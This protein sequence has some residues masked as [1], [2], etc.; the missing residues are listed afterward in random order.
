MRLV[1]LLPAM[2]LFASSQSSAQTR[3]QTTAPPAAAPS[4]L[5]GTWE[6]L[7]RSQ[8]G[9]GSIMIFAPGD[10]VK[11]IVSV[12]VD[13]RYTRDGNRVQLTHDDGNR[14]ELTVAITGDTLVQ[15]T[16]GKSVSMIR[17]S[18]SGPD[19]GIVGRWRFPY[20]AP[21]MPVVLGTMEYTADGVNR[22]RLPLQT[23]AGTYSISGSELTVRLPDAPPQTGTFSIDGDVLTLQRPDG[24]RVR[25]ARTR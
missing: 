9:I 21:Q 18:G 17:V 4:P 1:P 16:A 22:L 20:E 25:F 19:S 3:S 7:D 10:S 2:L 23:R 12:M 8:G 24:T 6:S 13:G 5:A 14:T 15:T 11:A